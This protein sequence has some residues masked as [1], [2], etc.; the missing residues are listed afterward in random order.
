MRN[1]EV[2]KLL[3]RLVI[4]N[5]RPEA[6]ERFLTVSE[7]KSVDSA[8]PCLSSNLIFHTASQDD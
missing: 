7:G 6:E 1:D 5:D 8:K 3:D 4:A 2:P